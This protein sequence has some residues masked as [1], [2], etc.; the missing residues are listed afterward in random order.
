[1]SVGS[2]IFDQYDFN[3]ASGLLRLH[4]R[5]ENGPSFIEKIMFPVP[6]VALSP[7]RQTA[8]DG[9]FRLILLLAGVSYYKAYAPED[10][11]CGAFALD[12][13]TANFMA[14]I[15][16]K[17][18]AEFYFRNKLEL[19]RPLRFK[20]ENVTAR[21]ANPLGLRR[22]A[23]IPVG[24]GKDSIVTLETLKRAQEPATLFALG[25]ASG[26][27][28][29]IEATIKQSGL[30]AL[31]VERTLWPELIELNKAAVFNGHVP[32][33][34]ILSAI[35]VATAILHDC[36]A[37]ILS[38]EY[39]AN[40]PNLRMNEFEINHQYSK[41]LDFERNF[42]S[43]VAAHIAKDL[44]YF[45][46]LRPFSEVEIARRFAHHTQYH[47]IFRSCNKAF[48]QDGNARATQW[49]CNCPKCR[50][51]FLALA[52]FVDKPHMIE[53]FGKNMLDDATQL[54]GFAELCGLANYKPFECVGEVEESFSLVQK[55]SRDEN[56]KNDL[57]VKN[58][59]AQLNGTPD[60]DDHYRALFAPHADHHVPEEYVRM[61]DA[62]H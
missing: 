21:A 58:L 12:E 32:I 14:R 47:P 59:T 56:W 7:E 46:L 10:L 35:A 27:A 28:A 43:Y 61:L 3:A 17:G 9:A 36:D 18:L 53:I 49:C 30:H 38:N 2:F 4:Y 1:M 57:I 54:E 39:S 52:P 62:D 24:G 44:R 55:L 31:R 11:V 8:L 34:A 51:V 60:F 25:S 50:F 19:D 48:K 5:F 20:T 23:L 40:A 37:V 45:S 29:P 22:H 26:I 13:E 16:R 33:T 15:Y 42:A 41:S 6:T